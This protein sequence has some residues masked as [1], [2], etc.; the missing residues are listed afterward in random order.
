MQA[1]NP[2]SLPFAVRHH[3]SLDAVADGHAAHQA[4]VHGVHVVEV[5]A[6]RLGVLGVAP[7]QKL[8]EVGVWVLAHQLVLLG[9]QLH[10]LVFNLL[11]HLSTERAVLEL[12]SERTDLV[13]VDAREVLVR[14]PRFVL[15]ASFR[16]LAAGQLLGAELQIDL[17]LVG[18]HHEL[19]IVLGVVGGQLV[20]PAVHLHQTKVKGL[21][22]HL[23]AVH[24]GQ[25]AA[26]GF[27]EEQDRAVGCRHRPLQ[28]HLAC[29]VPAVR[30]GHTVFPFGRDGDVGLLS[31]GWR[32]G[33]RRVGRGL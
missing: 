20:K 2:G 12:L 26:L 32:T 21:I 1:K 11:L 33:L 17:R 4:V 24:Q 25:V 30:V 16:R 18:V 13:V 28:A 31:G 8:G 6:L 22:L 15:L 29:F 5:V 9:H 10:F 7:A 23:G 14:E 27:V 19:T 3:E